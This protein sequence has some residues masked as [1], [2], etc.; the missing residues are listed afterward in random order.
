[1]ITLRTTYI[2]SE[3]FWQ[4]I[5]ANL[6]MLEEK[7]WAMD[8]AT[9]II[10]LPEMFNSGFSMQAKQLA[11]P[12]N[13]STFRWMGRMARKTNAAIV[14]SYIVKEASNYYNRLY[15]VEPDGSFSFYDKRHLFRMGKEHQTFAA[16]KRRMVRNFRGFK[17]MPM[18]CYDLRFPVWSKNTYDAQ[19]DA[20]DYDLLIYVANWP[21]P[22]TD[23]WTT[24]LKAR[25]LENQSYAIGVNRIG[26]DG[27]GI[28]YDGHSAIYD[29][30]GKLMNSVTSQADIQTI[31]LNLDELSEFRKNFPVYLDW[32]GFEIY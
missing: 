16:G 23:T 14:G 7:I 12:M 15:W 28:D 1:M 5:D 11:E 30:K 21:K 18:V 3:L 17:V 31:T 27:E 13:Y 10:I 6:A 25:A 9:D 29:Y 2:Q 24:L 19:N 22:R 8:E 4:D 20:F 26:A 32:D